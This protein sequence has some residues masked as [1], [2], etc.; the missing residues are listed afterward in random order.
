[1]NHGARYEQLDALR[2]LAA[3]TVV[4]SHFTLLT[5]LLILRH[6]PLRVLLGG[7]EAVV[8]FF[9]LSGFVLTLQINGAGKPGYYE[10]AIRRICRIYLPYLGA[11]A[12]AYA[13]F[14]FSNGGEVG[15]A[16]PW[17]NASWPP[18]LSNAD[19]A[20]HLMFLLPFK[21]DQ[22]DNVVWS[23]VYEMRIS[24]VFMPIVLAV[25]RMPTWLSLVGAA[26]L[27]LALCAYA[28]HT[29]HPLIQASVSAE[30]LPTGHYLSMFVVGAALAK[31]RSALSSHLGRAPRATRIGIVLA[32]SSFA[33]YVSSASLRFHFREP[34]SGYLIDWCVLL[35]VSGIIA[36]AVALVPFARLLLIPPLPF[37]G[38]ISYSLYLFH[39]VVLLSVVHLTGV[40]MGPTLSLILAAVL[41]VPVSYV[42]YVC[43]ERPGIRLG[44][45]LGRKFSTQRVLAD[46]VARN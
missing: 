9:V 40:R 36:C 11:I 12:V 5:P 17:F 8:L 39:C 30:W 24:L 15:W 31:H 4:L 22:L 10:Y 3:L 26:S 20:R 35:A 2:G 41:I 42:G 6:T 32:A 7:H 21:T 29:D 38:K 27:S 46:A 16:G 13:C 37:L 44:S 14:L 18:A 33:L 43:F 1:M 34:L 23:L 45:H 25:Y 19:L 28:V